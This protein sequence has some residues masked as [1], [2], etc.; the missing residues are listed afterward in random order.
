MG[1]LLKDKV[2]PS[3][4][5]ITLEELENGQFEV[6]CWAAPNVDGV[7]EGRWSKRFVALAGAELEYNRWT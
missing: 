1:E 3:G 2:L 6:A 4:E 5:S 7:Q